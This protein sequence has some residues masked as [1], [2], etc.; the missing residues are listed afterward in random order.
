ME[1]TVWR[2]LRRGL[3]WLLLSLLIIIL[4]IPPAAYILGNWWLGN[5]AADRVRFGD[6]SVQVFDPYLAWN[7][8]VTADSLIFSSPSISAQ[9]SKIVADPKVVPSILALKPI[10]DL[11]LDSVWVTLPAD[12]A[13]TADARVKSDTAEAAIPDSI[14]FPEFELPVRAALSAQYAALY[15]DTAFVVA[16]H[17]LGVATGA[18]EAALY[19][20]KV[21]YSKTDSLFPSVKLFVD[22]SGAQI[23]A[24]LT[25]AAGADSVRLAAHHSK[26]NLLRA[27]DTLWVWVQSSAAYKSYYPQA[28]PLIRNLDAKFTANINGKYQFGANLDAKA[29]GIK[30]ELPLLLADQELKFSF[31]LD[32]TTGYWSLQSRGEQEEISL[33]ADLEVLRIDSLPDLANLVEKV[34]MTLSG[35]IRGIP[36]QLGGEW[37]QAGITIP[38]L[39]ATNQRVQGKIITTDGTE[40]EAEAYKKPQVW[41]GSFD[42]DVSPYERLLRV[43]VDTNIQFDEAYVSGNFSGSNISASSAF[44]DVSAYG[45]LADSLHAYHEFSME[46]GYTLQPSSLFRD[47]TVWTLS[48]HMDVAG[49]SRSMWWQASNQEYGTLSYFMPTAD[50][51]Y[52]LAEQVHLSE[53]PYALIPELPVDRPV[54]SAEFAW[55]MQHQTG[56]ARISEARARY[57][58]TEL[59]VEGMMSWT[60]SLFRLQTVR[61]QID[62]SELE[63]QTQLRLGGREF[64]E[65]ASLGPE[66][67][68]TFALRADEFD[69]AKTLDVFTEQPPLE[70]GFVDGQFT[71]T[72]TGGFDGQYRFYDIEML[73]NGG[74]PRLRA[75]RINGNGDTLLINAVTTSEAEPL[76]NDSL[77]VAVSGVLS[78]T[79]HVNVFLSAASGRLRAMIDGDIESFQTFKGSSRVMG[80]A[81]LPGDIGALRDI[82]FRGNF[83]VPFTNTLEEMEFFTD[84]LFTTYA[85][86]GIDT[87]IIR[88][89]PRISRGLLRVPEL[90]VRNQKG[91]ELTGSAAYG[92]VEEQTTRVKLQGEAFALK[93]GESDFVNLGDIEVS[94]YADS[95]SMVVNADI[96]RAELGYLAPPLNVD[97]MIQDIDLQYRQKGG[98]AE[99]QEVAAAKATPELDF[100]GTLR[101]MTIGYRI[102]SIQALQNIFAGNGEERQRPSPSRDRSIDL[103]ISLQTEGTKNSI[104]SDVLRMT[105]TTDINIQGTYPYALAN[106]RF[107]A[108]EGDIG[109]YGQSYDIR[110]LPVKWLTVPLEEGDITME[111]GKTLAQTCEPEETDSCDVYIRLGGEL[112]DLQFTYDTDCGGEFGAGANVSAI[113]FSVRRGCYSPDFA[114]GG[115]EQGYG[116][117]ALSLLEPT[118][119]QTISRLAEKYTGNWIAGTNITGLGALAA[120]SATQAIALEIITKQFFGLRLRAKAG[121]RP[122][123]GEA[124]T[125]WESRL[126]LEWQPPLEEIITN[127]K[128]ENLLENNIRIEASISTDPENAESTLEDEI[129]KR[130]GII[131][132][133]KF[134]NLW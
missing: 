128:W 5:Y 39:R 37:V 16:V 28:L 114:G 67:V 98:R 59:G 105:F 73:Q 94:M 119:S 9:S 74:V 29:G 133:Y 112:E 18:K 53:V 10:V 50:S 27:S 72:D 134:W 101:G 93:W 8:T 11:N 108:L 24:S 6:M 2:R 92:L 121:Y 91:Q 106:G 99:K 76:F 71:Y 68:Q 32:D 111:A 103:D 14:S 20:D 62:E 80:T 26:N 95:V 131:Y 3:G 55:H 79:Q 66:H 44:H 113:I 48:G 132:R 17:D 96:G 38:R 45:G 36:L 110:N 107:S 127:N 78:D 89:K 120:D 81:P 7:L 100:Q 104:D 41:A 4:L 126:G 102:R 122:D 33:R 125:P 46:K 30:T 54:V 56:H 12:S 19:I 129:Q 43:F 77:V 1:A 75:L 64:F 117:Q 123:V 13:D 58:G 130:L 85:V 84:T 34:A 97:G 49:D 35:H 22:W 65:L 82:I 83:E 60:D 23:D 88:A 31:L 109:A 61:V 40:I 57:N 51:M 69:I 15:R 47:T 21:T 52:A 86:A 116:S 118:I 90:Y 63:A 115:V 42:L 124:T 25:V 70:S 87:Q